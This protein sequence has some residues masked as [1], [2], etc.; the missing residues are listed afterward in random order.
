MHPSSLS[1]RSLAAAVVLAA[2]SAPALQAAPTNPLYADSTT[3]VP[4]AALHFY[5]NKE[6]LTIAIGW[7]DPAGGAHSNFIRMAGGEASGVHAH[8]ASYYGVV[9]AGVAANEPDGASG[10]RPLATGS[11]WYQKGGEYHVTKCISRS[12]CLFFVT[13]PGAFDYLP[14]P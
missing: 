14:K 11:Y 10:D 5:K 4:A 3:S 8:T 9:I 2:L 6:G 12:G 1:L 7:G 13:S